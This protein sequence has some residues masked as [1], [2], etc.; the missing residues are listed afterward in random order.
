MCAP[1][2]V[3][4]AISKMIKEYIVNYCFWP[5]PFLKVSHKIQIYHAILWQEMCYIQLNFFWGLQLC[6]LN[7]WHIENHFSFLCVAVSTARKR[8]II[9]NYLY[10]MC[11]GMYLFFLISF[12]NTKS[13]VL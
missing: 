11:I 7:L 6:F 8:I 9:F 13:D 5:T 3:F 12:G 10:R 1:A 2:Q 4:H